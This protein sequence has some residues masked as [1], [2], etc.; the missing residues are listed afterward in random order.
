MILNSGVDTADLISLHN[1]VKLQ[2]G[3]ISQIQCIDEFTKL[4]YSKYDFIHQE[5]V[6]NIPDFL[7]DI[8]HFK[9]IYLCMPSQ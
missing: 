6:E 8:Y 9:E 3:F 5:R 4:N 7:C 2:L 1:I